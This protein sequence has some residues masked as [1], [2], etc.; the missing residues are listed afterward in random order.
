MRQLFI[1]A[2]ALAVGGLLASTAARAEMLYYPGGPERAG[3]M[4]QISTDGDK[5]YGYWAPCPAAPARA[6]Q[7]GERAF[8]RAPAQSGTVYYPGGPERAGNMCQIST[9]GDKLYGY[10]APCAK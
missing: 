8:D 2:A 3:T 1:A 10:W 5:L 7:T 6:A 4:C 9:D